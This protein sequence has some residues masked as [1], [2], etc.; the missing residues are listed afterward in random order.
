MLLGALTRELDRLKLLSPSLTKPF[1]LLSYNTLC[2]RL[3]T[4]QSPIWEHKSVNLCGDS[5][6]RAHNCSL[7]TIVSGVVS[8]DTATSI[9]LDL[10]Q[11]KDVKP[12]SFD[13]FPRVFGG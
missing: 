6:V 2:D 8:A 12:F 9:G 3:K 10:K 11:T 5:I 1:L 13:L 7:Q 4:I